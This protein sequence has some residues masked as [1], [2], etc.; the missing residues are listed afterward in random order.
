M[1]EKLHEQSITKKEEKKERKKNA[2][3]KESKKLRK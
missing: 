2:R 3:M 1:D